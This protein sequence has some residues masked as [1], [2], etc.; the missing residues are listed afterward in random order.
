MTI[1]EPCLHVAAD[2]AHA[3]DALDSSLRWLVGIPFLQLRA[4]RHLHGRFTSQGDDDIGRFEIS[5][6]DRLWTALTDIDAQLVQ[7]LYRE[8]VEC[9]A[10]LRSGRDRINGVA[11]EVAHEPRGHVG[12]SAVFHT[13]EATTWWSCHRVSWYALRPCSSPVGIP[14]E[15][16]SAGAPQHDSASAVSATGASQEDPMSAEHTPVSG[17][18]SSTL[19]AAAWSPARAATM[20][21]ICS[22]PVNMR[23]VGARPYDFM[24]AI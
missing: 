20:E 7:R 10:G 8:L 5:L 18:T 23:N 19:S 4:R 11:G 2:E 22:Y 17:R 3:L 9:C 13:D 12:L 6:V 16:G 15:T 21:R 14:I 24:P 1:L